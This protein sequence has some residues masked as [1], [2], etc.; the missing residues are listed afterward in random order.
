MQYPRVVKPEEESN[1]NKHWTIAGRGSYPTALT[2]I[3][4]SSRWY[5]PE[6]TNFP[7]RSITPKIKNRKRKYA[8]HEGN[9]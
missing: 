9:K 6:D 2:T 8:R 7:A 4:I 5:S 3:V 1:V